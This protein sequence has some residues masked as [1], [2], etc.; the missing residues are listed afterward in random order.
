[1]SALSRAAGKM[2][3]DL[4]RCAGAIHHLIMIAN[5]YGISSQELVIFKSR[6]NNKIIDT[7]ALTKSKLSTPIDKLPEA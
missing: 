3:F 5:L 2:N 1:M 6:L 7:Y 4:G